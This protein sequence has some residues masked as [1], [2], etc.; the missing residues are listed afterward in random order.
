MF[1]V[2]QVSKRWKTASTQAQ[3][4]PLIMSVCQSLQLVKLKSRQVTAHCGHITACGPLGKILW[5]ILYC[6]YIYIHVPWKSVIAAGSFSSMNSL[7]SGWESALLSITQAETWSA[8]FC[9]FVRG[10]RRWRCQ[11]L[12]LQVTVLLFL[13][14][15]ALLWLFLSWVVCP[16]IGDFP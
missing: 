1:W 10:V 5:L 12:Q 9:W 8:H 2:G 4:A 15:C 13:L 11:S 14:R 16:P 6:T 3:S 7:H